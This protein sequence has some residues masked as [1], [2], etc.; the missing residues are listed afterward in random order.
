[1]K[2]E[3]NAIEGVPIVVPIAI[4]VLWLTL[5]YIRT[6]K[7]VDADAGRTP[8]LVRAGQI[9]D[10]MNTWWRERV[11]D[12][13]MREQLDLLRRLGIE[14]PDWRHLGWGFAGALFLWL[15]WVTSTLQR[16][17]AR[18]KPDRVARAWIKATGKLAKV[19][20]P[21]APSEGAMD[22]A[23]RIADQHPRLATSVTEIAMRYTR[24][25]FGREAANED[26]IELERE[27]SRL[28]V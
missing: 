26:V 19:A 23:R 1:M 12:F 4:G 10:S 28:V 6:F 9:W 2:I 27:V 17:V 11:L 22:Y 21:R 16:S 25:R 3:T 24:L 8:W 5:M 20:A 15:A 18:A 13:N 14:A 7:P